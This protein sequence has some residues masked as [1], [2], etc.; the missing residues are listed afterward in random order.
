MRQTS[1]KTWYRISFYVN[2]LLMLIVGIFFYLLIIDSIAYGQDDT[3]SDLWL[4]ITRDVAFIAIALTI[5]F[6]QFIRNLTTIM[7]RS[8]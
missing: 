6:I 2:I 8:L 7:K 4:Y 1:K 5:I 3:N